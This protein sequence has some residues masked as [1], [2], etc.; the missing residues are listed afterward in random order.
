MSLGSWKL[1]SR[2]KPLQ[3]PVIED[4][5]SE[6]DML[7]QLDDLDDGPDDWIRDYIRPNVYRRHTAGKPLRVPLL[8]AARFT[9][10]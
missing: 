7:D 5:R 8:D 10:G 1:R 3:E 9:H 6:N 4:T 2:A